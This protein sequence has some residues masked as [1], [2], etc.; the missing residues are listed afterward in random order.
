M[1]NIFKKLDDWADGKYD[2][3]LECTLVLDKTFKQNVMAALVVDDADDDVFVPIKELGRNHNVSSKYIDLS[4]TTPGDYNRFLK[5]LAQRHHLQGI[6]I[7]NIDK[8][9]DMADRE[10]WEEFVRFALKKEPD[11]PLP[12]GAT[13]C[14]DK[15]HVAARCKTFPEYLKGCS[16]QCLVISKDTI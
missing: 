5:F 15:I 11:F 7:D 10:Y 1:V 8:I 4:D 9:P 6:L 14:F 13:I 3:Y 12:G 2:K 16:M